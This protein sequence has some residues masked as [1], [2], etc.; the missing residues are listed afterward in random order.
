MKNVPQH[1]RII[2]IGF[3]LA[4]AGV[5]LPLLMVLQVIESTFFLNFLAYGMSIAGL[6]LGMIGA[7]FYVAGRRR[8]DE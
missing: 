4:V 1:V 8:R 7:A 6:I 2:G 3:L 5:V